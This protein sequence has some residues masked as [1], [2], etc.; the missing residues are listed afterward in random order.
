MRYNK[1]LDVDKDGAISCPMHGSTYG[2][3][4]QP[5]G[6]PAT[7]ALNWYQT[8]IDK[9]GAISTDISK[10]IKQGQWAELPDWAKKK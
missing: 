3:D 5:T 9:E 10:T 6:G 4:G 7:Q 8:Q 2:L 1:R